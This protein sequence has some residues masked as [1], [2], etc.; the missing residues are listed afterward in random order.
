MLFVVV[1]GMGVAQW[2]G[3]EDAIDASAP[4]SPDLW[5]VSPLLNGKAAGFAQGL[6]T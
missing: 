2:Y 4:P 5:P 3:G 1:E 6:R